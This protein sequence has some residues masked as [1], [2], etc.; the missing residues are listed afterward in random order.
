MSTTT[1]THYPNDD[2]PL[3]TFANCH[4]GIV[5]H[6]N[7]LGELPALLEPAM[8]ARRI[9][10][11]TLTFFRGAVFDHH[12]EEEKDL[13]PAVLAAAAAGEE[14]AKVQQL[15]DALKAEH[16]SIE[17]LWEEI[18]PQLTKVAK[19]QLVALD[20]VAV[21]H[22]VHKYIAHAKLEEDQFLP[23]S[24]TILGRTSDKMAALG[25]QLHMRHVVRAA[26]RG[27]RGS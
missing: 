14:R 27:M 16:R 10:E 22:L 17:A 4:E 9:A 18:E 21:G 15:V 3:A 1:S 23:L 7:S 26:H 12:V 13:F 5:S 11:E 20:D 25:L 8:R 19:G 2:P 24:E 6:L